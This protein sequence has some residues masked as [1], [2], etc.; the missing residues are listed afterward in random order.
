MNSNQISL[1]IQNPS[2]F[3]AS[4]FSFVHGLRYIQQIS[5]LS[6]DEKIDKEID[7]HFATRPLA[8]KKLFVNPYKK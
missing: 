4:P 2:D 5:L 1:G 3:S 8:T 6:V 7:K